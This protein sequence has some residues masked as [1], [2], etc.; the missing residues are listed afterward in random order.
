[1]NMLRSDRKLKLWLAAAA[2][3]LAS[4]NITGNDKSPK[5]RPGLIVPGECIDGVKLGDSRERVERLLGKPTSS[6]WADGPYR[7][8]RTYIYKPQGSD[9]LGL[10]ISFLYQGED[11]PWGPVDA[12]R[13]FEPYTG[14]TREGIGIG[15]TLNE[16]LKAFGEPEHILESISGDGYRQANYTWCYGTTKFT[17]GTLQ[18]TV[19]VIFMGHYLPFQ[20]G[21][22]SFLC[23]G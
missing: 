7:A 3:I 17:V 16:V 15:S 19:Q 10:F 4:C 9:G 5:C 12:I 8:W 18:D 11:Q 22:S 14:K 20:E 13:V 21:Q 1:M 2:L 6:G 23:S